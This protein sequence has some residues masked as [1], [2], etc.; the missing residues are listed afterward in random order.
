MEIITEIHFPRT[1]T[2]IQYNLKTV[3]SKGH[4]SLKDNFQSKKL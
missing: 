1:I 3:E 2:G 4:F